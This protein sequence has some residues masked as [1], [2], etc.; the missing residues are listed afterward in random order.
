MA[1]EAPPVA[2]SI[3]S[4]SGG[5]LDEVLALER[6]VFGDPWP[7]AA[8]ETELRHPWSW[9]RLLGPPAAGAGVAAVQAYQI[10]WLLAGDMH[11]LKMAVWPRLRR[12]GLGRRLLDDALAEF[13][14]RGGGRAGLEVRRS[15]RIA[16]AFYAAAGFEQV[17]ERRAYYRNGEDALVLLKRVAPA[18]ELEAG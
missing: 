10:S 11:L 12:Q 5:R 9:F 14:R 17:G 1:C 18:D 7:A 3:V 13:A 15:N 8:F 4:A 16:Q 2:P 6:A